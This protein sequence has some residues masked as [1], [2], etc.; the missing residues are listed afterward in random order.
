M[1]FSDYADLVENELDKC[2]LQV[3]DEEFE[4][5]NAGSLFFGAFEVALDNKYLVEADDFRVIVGLRGS[6]N[7]SIQRGL[8]IGEQVMVCSNM[9]FSGSLGT[10]KT[11][12]TTNIWD[13]IPA[14]VAD[15]VNKIP[16]RAAETEKRL[17]EYK[18]TL[19]NPTQGDQFL[20]ELHRRGGLSATQLGVAVKEWD[21][22]SY[23][24]HAAYN[25]NT[26]YDRSAWQLYNACT[27]ALK[28]TGSR[29]QSTEVVRARSEII[30][31]TLGESLALA[32]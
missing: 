3:L 2:G 19:L 29:L 9:C 22:P 27:E 31:D 8:C 5:T 17:T 28:P 12:Q 16:D 25:D 6:H 11:K 1:P 26:S 10:F 13:R 14:L 30:V 15:A 4:V 7:Q 32:A 23:D 18:S 24:A 21:R 20:I